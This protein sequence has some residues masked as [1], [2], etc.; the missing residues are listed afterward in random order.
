MQW[1]ALFNDFESQLAAAHRSEFDEDV[2]ERIRAEQ[3]TVEFAQRCVASRG[4]SVRFSLVDGSHIEGT[5]VDATGT[6][7]LL[8][9]HATHVLPI[10][11]V[12]AAT[13]LS[14]RAPRMSTVMREL[15]IGHPL[16]ALA[17][18]SRSIVVRTGS[19]IWRG[20][21]ATVGRDYI[22]M[23]VDSGETVTLRLETVILISTF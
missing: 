9:D 19:G 21:C 16:R 1:E 7:L 14:E 10:N 13:G 4:Q 11:A 17:A 2:A 15:A 5:V 18:D 3:A 6:W 20:K 12:A 22:D 8:K 23:A